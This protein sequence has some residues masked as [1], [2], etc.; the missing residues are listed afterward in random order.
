MHSE[1]QPADKRL[2]DD[3][4]G[5]ISSDLLLYKYS[6]NSR[7]AAT[8]PH[9]K[10]H[11][12]SRSMRKGTQNTHPARPAIR[13]LLCLFKTLTSSSWFAWPG[14]GR[15]QVCVGKET[16]SWA[17]LRN[18]DSE[19]R[20][21]LRHDGDVKPASSL[22]VWEQK[23]SGSVSIQWSLAQKLHTANIKWVLCEG[24]VALKTAFGIE[25]F[26]K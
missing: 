6:T 3:A 12:T 8:G 13:H 18:Y 17:V 21:Y 26:Q 25:G 19:V 16:L 14:C 10:Q 4:S 23:N 15:Y 11:Q 5:A 2:N 24:N 7:W 22:N 9:Q 1:G 20:K